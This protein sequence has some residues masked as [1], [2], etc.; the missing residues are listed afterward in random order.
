[1]PQ[2]DYYRV[3][4]VS[5]QAT[6][7]EIKAAFRRLARQYHPD[8]NP[9]N[10]EAAEEFR[11]ICEAYEALSNVE[12]AEP[13]KQ[14]QTQSYQSHYVQGVQQS[15][16]GNYQWAIHAFTQAL[17][18]NDQ[19][20]DAYLGRCQAR[21]ALGDD[22]GVIEDGYQILKLNPEFSQAHYYQGRARARLGYVESAVAAYTR[23]IQL[24]PDYAA[25]HY[26]RGNAHAAL[27]ERQAA[28]QDWQTAARLYR[29]QG[30]TE[31][32]QRARVK[33]GEIRDHNSP[34]MNLGAIVFL[35]Q[36]I[37]QAVTLL[38]VILLNPGGELL[39]AF[40]R[41]SAQQ[42]AAVGGIW[43]AIAALVTG[44]S[45][46]V[47][48]L[49]YTEWDVM[50]LVWVAGLSLVGAHAIA[51]LITRSRGSW[52]GDIFISGATLIPLSLFAILGGVT[53][54]LG[55]TLAAGVL[56]GSYAI[57]TLYIGCTQI[58]SFWERSAALT[59][60]L[61]LIASGGVTVWV[62]TQLL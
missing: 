27:K 40:G 50:L 31:G 10:P 56:T 61:M 21:Y 17:E 53:Q 44:I 42:A 12:E 51:R 23:A 47:Y 41:L 13:S 20:V 5:Q 48:D 24:T 30:D 2:S 25:A 35:Q 46:P 38:P 22:R 14:S 11:R 55:P 26:Y 45:L 52:A 37:I 34:S 16:Q 29:V 1:M 15:A 59:V 32:L 39:P 19:S 33:L 49:P 36:T 57:L 54:S 60:P 8:L 7:S 43:T 58:H 3:L 9:N 18:L 6:A 62:A 4:R 28:K